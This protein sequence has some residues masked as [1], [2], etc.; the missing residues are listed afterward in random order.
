MGQLLPTYTEFFADGGSFVLVVVF[1][2]LSLFWTGLAFFLVS[3]VER[4]SHCSTYT[5]VCTI[6]VRG[7]PRLFLSRHPAKQKTVAA[8][9]PA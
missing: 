7:L 3:R 9:P 1:C 8:A 6:C 4:T 5:H 2:R